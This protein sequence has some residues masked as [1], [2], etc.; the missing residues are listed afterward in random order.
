MILSL[1]TMFDPDRADGFSATLELRF[2][3]D[4]FRGR[5]DGGAFEIERGDAADPD[6]IVEAADPR[7]LVAVVF[8]GLPIDQAVGSGDLAITGDEA[9]VGRFVELFELPETACVGPMVATPV[10][11][12]AA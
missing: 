3:E 7:T 5:V 1:R 9:A 6:A 10:A 2:G 11:T 12:P 4:R 8:G